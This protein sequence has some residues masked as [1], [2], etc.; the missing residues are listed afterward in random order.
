[1]PLSQ[2]KHLWYYGLVLLALLFLLQLETSTWL[3]PPIPL[4]GF[5][6]L[7]AVVVR[8]VAALIAL[9]LGVSHVTLLSATRRQYWLV[10]IAVLALQVPEYQLLHQW[11]NHTSKQRAATLIGALAAY[12]QEQH[13][14]PDSLMQLVPRYLPKVPVTGFGTLSPAPFLY[15]SSRITADSTSYGL[16]YATGML[17]DATYNS[18]TRRWTYDD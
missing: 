4:L 13:H 5:L 14:Y 11:Q 3:F 7:L 16:S 2:R 18:H 12:H 6:A 17:V 8:G 10:G 15:Y 1:M 9:P